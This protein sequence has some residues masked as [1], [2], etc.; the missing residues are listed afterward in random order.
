MKEESDDER[1]AGGEASTGGVVDVCNADV[2][3]P[4]ALVMMLELC[5]NPNPPSNNASLAA[6]KFLSIDATAALV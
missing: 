4:A 5:D 2:L 6:S 1:P 3:L